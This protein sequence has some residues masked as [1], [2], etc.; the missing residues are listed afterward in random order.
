MKPSEPLELQ[1]SVF[2][3][4][5]ALVWASELGLQFLLDFL[6]LQVKIDLNSEKVV[7]HLLAWKLR[8]ESVV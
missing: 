3:Q 2:V 7:A 6:G 8:S 1:S 4:C 5:L